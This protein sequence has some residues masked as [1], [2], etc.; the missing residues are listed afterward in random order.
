MRQH[1]TKDQ[2][3]AKHAAA[4]H[5]PLH[6]NGALFIIKLQIRRVHLFLSD[7]QLVFQLLVLFFQGIDRA[8]ATGDFFC[9]SAVRWF[10]V[11]SILFSLSVSVL[12]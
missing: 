10:Q 8:I 9:M 7:N 5:K 12:T 4:V 3:D 11:A 1:Q 6:D 2:T